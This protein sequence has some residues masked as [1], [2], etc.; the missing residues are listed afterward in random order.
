L[1]TAPKHADATLVP[2]GRL[3]NLEE[4]SIHLS[5]FEGEALH[6]FS[7]LSKLRDLDLS[8]SSV[9]DEY[10]AGLKDL[11]NLEKLN[12]S[13]TLVTDAII[14]HLAQFPKLRQCAVAHSHLSPDGQARL[15]QLLDQRQ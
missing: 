4:L 14:D 3:E 12:L 2:I 9:H 10:I 1:E 11:P 15:Q 13:G 6:E 8:Q 5:S 7:R